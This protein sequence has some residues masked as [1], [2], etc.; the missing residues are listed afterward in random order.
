MTSYWLQ[1]ELCLICVKQAWEEAEGREEESSG[2][3]CKEELWQEG[4]EEDL[5]G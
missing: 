2:G 4:T 1:P 3:G 5:H